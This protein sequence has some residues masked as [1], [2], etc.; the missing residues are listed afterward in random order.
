MNRI[1]DYII[2]RRGGEPEAT[3]ATLLLQDF[4]VM[5]ERCIEP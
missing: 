3:E 4:G 5:F 1:P 2:K